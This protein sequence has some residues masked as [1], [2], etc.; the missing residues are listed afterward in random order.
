[1]GDEHES[2]T[3]SQCFVDCPT[4]GALLRASRNRKNPRFDSSGFEVVS[5]KCKCGRNLR[6]IVDPYDGRILLCQ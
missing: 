4:C 2:S 5:L 1:M 3:L 6:G